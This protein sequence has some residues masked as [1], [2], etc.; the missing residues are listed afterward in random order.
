MTA[1]EQLAAA[2]AATEAARAALSAADW[3]H[4]SIPEKLAK[5]VGVARRAL[6]CIAVDIRAEADRL[7]GEAAP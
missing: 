3:R 5:D 7:R 2:E 4:K 1:L 6:I